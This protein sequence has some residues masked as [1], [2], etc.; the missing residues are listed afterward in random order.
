MFVTL[1][2]YFYQLVI[3]TARTVGYMYLRVA[4]LLVC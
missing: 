1:C 2:R 3:D 4:L